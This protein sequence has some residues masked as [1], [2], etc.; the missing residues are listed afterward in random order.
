M[1][2]GGIIGRHERR[3]GKVHKYELNIRNPPGAR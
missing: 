2:S 3:R 1:I